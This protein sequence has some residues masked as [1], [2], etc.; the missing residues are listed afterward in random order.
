[1]FCMAKANERRS[2]AAALEELLSLAGENEVGLAA[3]FF[4][5]IDLAPA[6]G[7]AN[8]RAEG[9]GDSFLGGEAR[10]QMPGRKFHRHRV[11]DLALRENAMQESFAK[12][13]ERMLNAGAFDQVHPDAYNAHPR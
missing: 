5:H 12:T 11:F 7:F 1:M 13:I 3:R 6:H 4:A 9:F 2:A 8:A 10:G